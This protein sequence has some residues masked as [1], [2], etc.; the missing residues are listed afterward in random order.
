M[1]DS[2]RETD[3]VFDDVASS[4]FESDSVSEEETVSECEDER[5]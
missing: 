5:E 2:E 3:E 4:D 1:S